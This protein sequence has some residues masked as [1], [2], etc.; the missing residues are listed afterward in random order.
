MINFLSLNNHPLYTTLIYI[1]NKA[2]Q[3]ASIVSIQTFDKTKKVWQSM[4]Q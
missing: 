2:M 1:I 4:V 3:S